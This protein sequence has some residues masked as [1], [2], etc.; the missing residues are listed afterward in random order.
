M[1]DLLLEA[2][3]IFGEHKT[4]VGIT[5]TGVTGTASKVLEESTAFTS[6]DILTIISIGVGIL[7]GIY[8]IFGIALRYRELKEKDKCD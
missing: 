4:I 5:A 3:K 6:N 1:K 2:A 7:T 8:M